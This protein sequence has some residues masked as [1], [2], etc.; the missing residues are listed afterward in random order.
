MMAAVQIAAAQIP[1]MPQMP[2]TSPMPQPGANPMP[3]PSPIPPPTSNGGNNFPQ[4]PSQG[5]GQGAG[6][7]GGWCAQGDPTKHASISSN[8]VYLNLTNE[9][10]STSIGNLQGPNR[11]EAQ[12][13]Q[14][15]IGTLSNDGQQINW[16]NGTFWARCPS[17]GGGS[18]NLNGNWYPNGNR[19]LQCS[20][21]QHRG[22][23]TLQNETGQRATGS[24]KGKRQVTTNWSGTKITGTV[25]QD[26]NRIDWSNG[27]YWIRYKVY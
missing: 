24:I 25:S 8:G 27:T 23:L 3:M 26:G 16:S 7:L 22:N 6:F 10:G 13:W 19:A 21:Q 2:Q 1:G 20:I 11:I 5:V 4:T 12:E 14:F 9:S 17:G 15:V 18:P